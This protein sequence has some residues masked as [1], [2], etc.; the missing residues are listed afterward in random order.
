MADEPVSAWREPW[1]RKLMRWLTRHRTGVTA[2]GA[3]GLVA[4]AGTAAV[5]AVQT[6]ANA[7]L[8]PPTRK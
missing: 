5:L 2:A 6:Q 7:A 4:L 3:A 1:T 8:R